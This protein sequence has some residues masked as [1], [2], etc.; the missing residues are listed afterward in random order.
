MS[1]VEYDVAFNRNEISAI[2][3]RMTRFE[4][5]MQYEVG[6]AKRFAQDAQNYAT[7][8]GL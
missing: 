2:S 6:E 5:R 7:R 4:G 3:S 1:Q 8:P